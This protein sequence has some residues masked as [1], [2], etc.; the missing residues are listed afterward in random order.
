[1][2]DPLRTDTAEAPIEGEAP[3]AQAAKVEGLLL[4]GLD[5]YFAGEYDQAI[6]VWTR[7]LFLDR[8]HTRARAYIDRA[9]SALAEQQRESEELLQNG[10]VAFERGE[11]GTARRLLNSAVERG[12]AHDVALDL[13]ARLNRLDR[14]AGSAPEARTA[15]V[16]RSARSAGASPRG[17][18]G[19]LWPAV[20]VLI[21]LLAGL[22]GIAFRGR[23]ASWIWS[24][25]EAP[26]ELSAVRRADAPVPLLRTS[27]TA[28]ARA[29]A[30][31]RSGRLHD[32]LRAVD[33]VRSTDPL[34]A[35]ADRL[36]AEIQRE[37]LATV[38]PL[39]GQGEAVSVP[40]R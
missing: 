27:E 18:G 21:L 13:L 8:G 25:S 14:A 23:I 7:V 17:D 15:P 20:A 12:G 37:L 9:R 40:R 16:R 26:T 11:A 4:A 28:V 3:G 32:A 22:A 5:H 6:N 31:F 29:R 35:E 30:L 33:P 38:P 10:V 36:K 19:R 34:R 1:M 24:L 2:S 39:R